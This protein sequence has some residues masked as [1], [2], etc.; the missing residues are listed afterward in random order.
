MNVIV[1]WTE[2]SLALITRQVNVAVSRGSLE[3]CPR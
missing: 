1:N 2:Q 3:S